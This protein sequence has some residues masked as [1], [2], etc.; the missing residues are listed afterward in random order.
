MRLKSLGTLL[1]TGVC[2]ISGFC[3]WGQVPSAFPGGRLEIGVNFESVR[4]NTVPGYN[5]WMQGG[6]A[7]IAANFTRHWGVAADF[8]G[9]HTGQMPHMTVGLDLIT[10]TFGPRY[11]MTSSHGRF[12]IFGEAMG[13]WAHGGNSLFPDPQGATASASGSALLVGGGTD[14]QVARRFSVRLLDADWLRTALSNG[15]TTVQNSLRLGSG[16]VFRF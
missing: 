3:A 2:A 13:G 11:V 16:V 5:F 14:C 7:Q 1:A 12:R 10:A 9:V 6:S 4:A 8:S 15:T